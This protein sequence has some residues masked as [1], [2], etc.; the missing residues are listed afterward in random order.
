MLRNNSQIVLSVKEFEDLMKEQFLKG[1][2]SVEPVHGELLESE[3][4]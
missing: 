1:Q 4:K 3:S 2:N